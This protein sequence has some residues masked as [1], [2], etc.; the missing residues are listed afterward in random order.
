VDINPVASRKLP[1][2]EARLVSAAIEEVAA[3]RSLEEEAIAEAGRL[4]ERAIAGIE[5]GV[6]EVDEVSYEL[7]TTISTK[8][9]SPFGPSHSCI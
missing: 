4:Q 7:L 6:V 1:V 5:E 8:I 3:T 2:P 9:G